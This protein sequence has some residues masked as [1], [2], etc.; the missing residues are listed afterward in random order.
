M[1][2]TSFEGTESGSGG[3]VSETANDFR[4]VM[5]LRDT[6]FRWINCNNFKSNKSN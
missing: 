4:K 1:L 2:N 3:D 5:L 6:K